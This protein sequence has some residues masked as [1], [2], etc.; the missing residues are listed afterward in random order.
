MVS[1]V[2]R[3]PSRREIYHQI[4]QHKRGD[5]CDTVFDRKICPPPNIDKNEGAEKLGEIESAANIDHGPQQQMVKLAGNT[6]ITD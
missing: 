2:C 6:L 1:H 4:S 5:G 3:V